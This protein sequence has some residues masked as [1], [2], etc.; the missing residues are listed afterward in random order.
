[1]A[2]AAFG[3]VKR[4]EGKVDRQDILADVPAPN[5][6]PG[7]DGPYNYLILGSDSRIDDP[8]MGE[9]SDTIMVLHVN[10]GLRSAVIVSIPRDSY[11]NVPA[12]GSWKGGMNKINAAFAFGGANLAAK[13]V[14]DLTKVPFDGAV[15]VDFGGI[16]KLV[17]VFGFV[18]I[19][20][21][22]D[23]T[24]MHTGRVWKQGCHDLNPDEAEDF[25]RQ[26]KSVPGGDFGRIK[27]QQLVV[28]ALAHQAVERGLLTH[29]FATDQLVS[30]I[31]DSITVDNNTNIRDLVVR[32]K[33]VD[34][35]SITF[36]TAPYKGTM[37]TDAGS[38]VE[39][40]MDATRALFDAV[41]ADQGAEFIAAHP[42][43]GGTGS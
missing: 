12:G 14:Y 38:S 28:K 31:A 6:P 1:V 29:P 18:H 9:R 10:K 34:P 42:G 3:L 27:D 40:D 24:S 15:I 39:L 16:Q 43:A 35:D 41:V 21:P 33:D 7:S 23:V 19:C 11:V 13:T 25:M 17:S 8:S 30:T 26:R 36:A 4:Y 20:L 37:N 32:L 5:V 22:Y 2:L